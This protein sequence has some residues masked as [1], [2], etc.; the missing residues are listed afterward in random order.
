MIEKEIVI[1]I[2]VGG[3]VMLLLVTGYDVFCLVTARPTPGQ[4]V[5]WWARDHPIIAG[6]FAA[7]VGAFMAHIF[8]HM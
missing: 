4:V 8:W 1:L 6:L 5:Q 2:A 3:P 7:F